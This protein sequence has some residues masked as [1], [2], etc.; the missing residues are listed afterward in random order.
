VSCA[1]DHCITCGD[2]AVPMTVVR[3]DDGLAHCTCPEGQETVE[4]A[5]VG[6]VVPG[7]EVLVH[8]GTALVRL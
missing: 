3:V 5:L 2:I 6:D 4:I 1:D 8:A 7:D